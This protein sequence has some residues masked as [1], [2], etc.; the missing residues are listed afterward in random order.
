MPTTLSDLS[1]D[2]DLRGRLL[3]LIRQHDAIAFARADRA[4]LKRKLDFLRDALVESRVSLHE[5]RG[6]LGSARLAGVG[7][8][9]SAVQDLAR[10][11]LEREIERLAAAYAA[12]ADEGSTFP[13]PTFEQLDADPDLREKLLAL[14]RQYDARCLANTDRTDLELRRLRLEA[15]RGEVLIVPR[16][17]GAALSPAEIIPRAARRDLDREIARIGAALAVQDE[18]A[19]RAPRPSE[20]DFFVIEVDDEAV[21]VDV[22]R[23][24]AL[25]RFD[26]T[27][28]TDLAGRHEGRT[29]AI[30]VC[31]EEDQ[32][33]A[34]SSWT[35]AGVGDGCRVTDSALDAVRWASELAGGRGSEFRRSLEIPHSVIS[36]ALAE[37]A[38]DL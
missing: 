16:M 19:G 38:E 22:V 37:R 20:R 30:Y 10:R 12:G 17:P 15:A 28:W 8:G 6:G 29:G 2:P 13:L 27:G 18:A 35:R 9:W 24:H 23:G 31:R 21:T 14:V 26:E 1:A 25:R 4:G 3:D 11:A 32:A 5:P 33:S 34:S 7:A 36:A